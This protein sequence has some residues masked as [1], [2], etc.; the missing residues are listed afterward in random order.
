M[1]STL[2]T[3]YL[4]YWLLLLG[5]PLFL[6]VPSHA[7]GGWHIALLVMQMEQPLKNIS[8]LFC[9]EPAL[10]APLPLPIELRCSLLTTHPNTT[11]LTEASLRDPRTLSIRTKTQLHTS[12]QRVSFQQPSSQPFCDVPS[13]SERKVTFYSTRW[14]AESPSTQNAIDISVPKTTCLAECGG[15][16]R[17]A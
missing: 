7:M 13:T 1:F 10:S 5:F 3:A 17:T 11:H 15:I 4:P 6:C 9:Q 2:W 16:P 12:S 14:V 8:D